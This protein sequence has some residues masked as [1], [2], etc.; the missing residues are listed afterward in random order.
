[1]EVISRDQAPTASILGWILVSCHNDDRVLQMLKMKV[2]HRDYVP[3]TAIIH[4]HILMGYYADSWDCRY[5]P[6]QGLS[7]AS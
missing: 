3:F 6:F 1:M 7:L 2:Y 4:R 5:L